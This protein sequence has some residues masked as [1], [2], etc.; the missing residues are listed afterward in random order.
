MVRFA[1]GTK[2]SATAPSELSQIS[3]IRLLNIGTL[4]NIWFSSLTTVCCVALQAETASVGPLRLHL[5]NGKL[6]F[7]ALHNN[8]HLVMCSS[9]LSCRARV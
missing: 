9:L 6:L 2:L 7:F 4:S 8:P 5:F 3:L 1:F